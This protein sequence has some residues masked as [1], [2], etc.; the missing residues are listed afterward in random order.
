MHAVLN[1]WRIQFLWSLFALHCVWRE[2]WNVTSERVSVLS[3]F[4]RMCMLMSLIYR[5]WMRN[6]SSKIHSH[7]ID[8]C[9]T[10]NVLHFNEYFF[11][12]N[13]WAKVWRWH[14]LICS[15]IC[16]FFLK[17]SKQKRKKW[18][19]E[20]VACVAS[21]PVLISQDPVKMFCMRVFAYSQII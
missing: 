1:E 6:M 8:G 4:Q 14:Q 2:N 17:T 19:D 13:C 21:R 10:F 9:D 7:I 12:F 3:S 16:I 11:Q 20:S 5:I 18:T 15:V